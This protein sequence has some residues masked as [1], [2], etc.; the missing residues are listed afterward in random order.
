[1][2][3]LLSESSDRV[4]LLPSRLYCRSRIYTGSAVAKL[5]SGAA[6]LQNGS[7]TERSEALTLPWSYHR[8]CGISPRP[9]GW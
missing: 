9:E 2:Y 8:R 1:M 7:R 5:L 3:I 4:L 6:E